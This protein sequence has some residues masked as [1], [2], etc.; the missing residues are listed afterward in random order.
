MAKI[1][2]E[3]VELYRALDVCM[4]ELRKE[5]AEN[6]SKIGSK[7]WPGRTQEQHDQYYR[8]QLAQCNAAWS[9]LFVRSMRI[10]PD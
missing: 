1:P 8:D 7:P 6:E 5:I 2:P 3:L 9:W 10:N 4:V